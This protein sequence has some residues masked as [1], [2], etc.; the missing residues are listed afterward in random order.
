[1]EDLKWVFKD[2]ITPLLQEYFYGD[3]G[4]IGLVLGNGFVEFQDKKVHLAVVVDEYGGTTGIVTLGH[5]GTWTVSGNTYYPLP[6]I[7]LPNSV[8]THTFTF[9]ATNTEQVFLLNYV[10]DDNSNLEIGEV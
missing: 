2:K 4:K 5:S 8:G 3:Y 10:N 1:M 7:V 9:T 6:F